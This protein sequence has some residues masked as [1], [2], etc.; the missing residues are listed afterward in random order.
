MEKYLLYQNTKKGW[1]EDGFHKEYWVSLNGAEAWYANGEL[2]RKDGPAVSRSDGSMEW[3]VR[4]KELTKKE[5]D[6][7]VKLG[8]E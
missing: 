2:H 1:H 3:W 5:F 8:S 7:L 6:K 4:G